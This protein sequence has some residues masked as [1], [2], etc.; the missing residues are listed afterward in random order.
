MYCTSEQ[1]KRLSDSE[2]I[3]LEQKGML[4]F[5]QPYIDFMK[6][7]GSGT[8]GG[9]ICINFPDFNIL[10]D[11]AEYDFWEY[12]DAPITKE[13]LCECV[14]IG[15]SIDGDY[16]AIHAKVKGY[17]LL[18]R[19]S[20]MIELFPYENEN[21]IGTINKIGKFLYD[22]EDLENYFEP[23]GNNHEFFRTADRNIHD[24]AGQ[25]KT[26]FQGDYLIENEYICEVFLSGMGGYVRFNL[27]SGVEAAVFYS[28]YG[29]AYFKKVKKF[30]MENGCR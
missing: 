6:T 21:F 16:I 13:Q 28:D 15:N 7:Y 2:L 10:K 30:L 9:A 24:L 12:K 11:F 29:M 27:S 25:F 22:E 26:I 19:D 5:P 4:K 3:S 20:D 23:V 14:V 17:I 8:Y 18:P 1:K